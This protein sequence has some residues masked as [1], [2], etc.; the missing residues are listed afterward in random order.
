VA[1]TPSKTLSLKERLTLFARQLPGVELI[2]DLDL[3]T[4]QRQ[5]QKAD[6]FFERRRIICE[7][8][9]FADDPTWK[10][11]DRLK[12]HQSRPEWPIFYGNRPLSQVLQKFPDRAEINRKVFEA[13]T[14][15]IQKA[16]VDANRQIRDTKKTFDLPNSG[17][18]LILGNDLIKIFSPEVIAHRVQHTLTKR[19]PAGEPQFPH[20]NTVWMISEN[21]IVEFGPGRTGIPALFY[22]NDVPDPAN[23]A[24]FTDALQA[25]WA[26]FHGAPIEMIEGSNLD[27]L[28]FRAHPMHDSQLKTPETL[29]GRWRRE[30]DDNPYLQNL[31]IARL[32]RHA[33][34]LVA[35]ITPGMLK[36]ASAMQQRESQR[37]M[38][39]WTHFLQEV[40]RRG[41]DMRE[42]SPMLRNLGRKLRASEGIDAL[43]RLGRNDLCPCGSGKKFKHCHGRAA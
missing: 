27:E 2:D 28:R 12:P 26:A 39:S 23:V 22:Q 15:A 30:Y 17:G 21:Y 36:G 19:T 37:L 7:T 18:L 9:T 33:E 14:T 11:E 8:K 38:R 35:R 13:T 43:A 16:I 6:F 10:V 1:L 34:R 32:I 40:D 20:I 5:A 31:S 29:A 3:T 41:L 42:F 25:H 4:M 24:G